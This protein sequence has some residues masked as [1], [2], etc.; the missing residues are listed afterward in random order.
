MESE[1]EIAVRQVREAEEHIT[2]QR[3]L[4]ADMERAGLEH[5]AAIA[6]ATLEPL[7]ATL[8]TLR[9]RLGRLKASE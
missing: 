7:E 3:E 5:A 4:I 1:L 8:T 9:E 6:M 2:Q